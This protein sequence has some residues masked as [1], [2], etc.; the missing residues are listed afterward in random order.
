MSDYSQLQNTL[1]DVL[2]RADVWLADGIFSAMPT[3]FFQL[4]FY[5]P[6]IVFC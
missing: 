4:L 6:P 1:L 3:I 5:S 2:T